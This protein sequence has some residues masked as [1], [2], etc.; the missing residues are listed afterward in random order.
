MVQF[1]SFCAQSLFAIP[2]QSF[3]EKVST[4]ISIAES[5]EDFPK[6]DLERLKEIMEDTTKKYC[7]P[8]A[9]LDLYVDPSKGIDVTTYERNIDI[10]SRKI[11]DEDDETAY[12]KFKLS[13]YTIQKLL[14]DAVTEVM[15]IM[16]RF[17]MKYN[18]EI[19]FSS[20]GEGESK[21]IKFEK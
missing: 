9:I 2:L 13:R 12:K 18:E 7:V 16:N 21:K 14:F 19:D 5:Q 20:M 17:F 15:T 1:I 10:L 8:L 6:E 3:S 4:A 11:K